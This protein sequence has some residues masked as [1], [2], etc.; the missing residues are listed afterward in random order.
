MNKAALT[1]LLAL[2]IFSSCS[3]ISLFQN[4]LET[5]PLKT[6]AALLD[7]SLRVHLLKNSEIGI[8]TPLNPDRLNKKSLFGVYLQEKLTDELFALGYRIIEI[9]SFSFQPLNTSEKSIPASAA[10]R[11]SKKSNIQK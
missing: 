2:T 8:F 4:S 1:M 10:V 5:I 3:R 11:F 9:R 7:E 6:I